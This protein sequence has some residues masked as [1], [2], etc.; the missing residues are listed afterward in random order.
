M[1]LS[2]S[3]NFT[4][5]F[6]WG[7]GCRYEPFPVEGG[8]EGWWCVAEGHEDLDCPHIAWDAH[9]CEWW[10]VAPNEWVCSLRGCRRTVS[11]AA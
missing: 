2:S 5:T 10:P 1:V 3:S 9:V 11:G 6:P 4:I 7:P 8:T